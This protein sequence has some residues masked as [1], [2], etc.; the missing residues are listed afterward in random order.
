MIIR[1][2]QQSNPKRV[3]SEDEWVRAITAIYKVPYEAA[4][5]MFTQKLTSGELLKRSVN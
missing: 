4:Q 2:E 3:M 1:Y 5:D